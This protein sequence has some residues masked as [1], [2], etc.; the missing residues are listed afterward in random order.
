MASLVKQD[1]KF[2]SDFDLFSK[3]EENETNVRLN[4][5]TTTTFGLNPTLISPRQ[6]CVIKKQFLESKLL[7]SNWPP[8]YTLLHKYCHQLISWQGVCNFK[9][10]QLMIT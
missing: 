3:R 2:L 8:L 4:S 5:L 10:V 1:G 6:I 7:A 9:I